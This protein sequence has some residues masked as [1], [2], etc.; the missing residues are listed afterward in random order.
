MTRRI[1]NPDDVATLWPMDGPYSPEATAAALETVGALLR[2]VNYATRRVPSAP[3]GADVHGQVMLLDAALGSVPQALRQL[4]A[5]AMA[6]AA[7]PGAAVTE[8]GRDDDP[9]TAPG[10]ATLAATHLADVADVIAELRMRGVLSQAAV[11]LGR[12][13]V[14][15]E[16]PA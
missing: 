13:Y 4:A 15:E 5:R 1:P 12:L 16:T 3:A 10:A 9:R 7:E 8:A 11:Q 2:Y 14:R 6:V